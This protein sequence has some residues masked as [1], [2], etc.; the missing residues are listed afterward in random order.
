M[1]LGEERSRQE[2][3]RALELLQ[4]TPKND[5]LSKIY[6]E[7]DSA[8][9]PAL[10]GGAELQD[11]SELGKE[12][13]GQCRKYINHCLKRNRQ[14]EL[15]RFVRFTAA[16]GGSTAYYILVNYGWNL[17]TYQEYL[18]PAQAAAIRAEGIVWNIYGL[19][20][21]LSNLE[22]K[23]PQVLWEAMK[24]CSSKNDNAKVLLAAMSLYYSK[25]SEKSGNII[26][27]LLPGHSEEK[28]MQL[29]IQETVDFLEDNL[30]DSIQNLFDGAAPPEEDLEQMKRFV[31]TASEKE[32]V[33]KELFAVIQKTR[34]SEYLLSMLSAA[35]F[36][37]LDHSAMC[38]PFLHLAMAMDYCQNRTAVL[39]IC[40]QIGGSAWFFAHIK[41]F[42]EQMPIPKEDYM[43]W[44]LKNCKFGSPVKRIIREHPQVV[45]NLITKL[46]SEEYQS[47]LAVTKG[48]NPTLYQEL[49]SLGQEEF[50]AKL[51]EELTSHYTNGRKEA[52]QYLQGEAELSV[53]YPFVKDWRNNYDYN[54]RNCSKIYSLK[55]NGLDQ[56]LYRRAVVLE[57]LCMRAR[58]FVSY[59][60]G[61]YQ[62]IDRATI[63]EIFQVFEAEHVPVSYQLEAL[64][65]IYDSFYAEKEKNSFINDCMMVM[66]LKN[67][68]WGPELIRLSKD[69]SAI[70]RFL[71]IRV[72]DEY[73]AE[74]KEELLSCAADSAKQVREI[75]TAV[76]ESRKEWEPEILQMLASK[77]SKER[78]MAVQVLGR[79]G[80]KQYSE[81]LK[82]A[83]EKEKSKKIKE[84]LADCLGFETKAAE[85]KNEKTQKDLVKEILKGGK[86]RK[87]S[88]IYQEDKPLPEVHRKDGTLAS[89]EDLAAIMVCYADMSIPGFSKDAVQISQELNPEELA[90]YM[91]QIFVRF[92]EANA[93]AKKK[94]VLYAASVHGG[95]RIIPLL[96]AQI[97]EWPKVSRGA[98]A[99]EAV[100]ALAL[101]GSSTAL[102]LVDQISRKFKFRQVKAAAS[103]ALTYAASQLGITKEELED[104]IVPDLGFDERMEQTVDY[105]T[106][107]FRVVLTSTLELEVYDENGKRLK[108]LPAPGKRD[109]PDKAGAANAAFKLLKK[110]LKT[111]VS[112]QKLRMEQALGFARLW[113]VEQW[114]TLFVKNPVMHQFA[115]GLIWG[116]Y[117]DGILKDTFRYMEDGSFNTVEEEEYPL[118]ES[119]MIGLVHPIEMEEEQL[120]AWKE[121]LSDYEVIQPVEQLDR[122]VYRLTEEEKDQTELI[123]FGGKLL[124]GLSLSGKLQS[125]GW[126]RGSV[127]DAGG[128]YTFYREDQKIGVE[129][130]F[131][132]SFVGGENEEVTVYGAQFYQAGTVQRGSY[133]YDTI[134]KEHL[135]RLSEVSPRY[136]SEIVLQLTKAT[137][138]SQEQ[139]SYPECKE[140]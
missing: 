80:A 126:Y 46:T 71:C 90:F 25:P 29:R 84:L 121:Q 54:T 135:Y 79:W 119:A 70:V 116:C 1:N 60:H 110:Q 34:I 16:V 88:W 91:E 61:T 97:Q 95:E 40:L 99:S 31:R 98:M 36:L 22:Q 19:K 133:V 109:E 17:H 117:E 123:R 96:H 101:N 7:L 138:S 48:V 35:A 67:K 18:S 64:S 93:E 20:G 127:Q 105:G 118:P 78:E 86:K 30:V 131:S 139:L 13:T 72:M 120:S 113:K 104:R 32:S 107:S 2:L 28:E 122:P 137:A 15:G 89:E 27:K 81:V 130:E 68:E 73:G 55:K 132:G 87:I 69:G 50:C 8:E 24:L 6:L 38:R 41:D 75:L 134:K 100:K 111:V 12:A 43:V 112:N 14:E 4:L 47:L 83:Y 114:E 57:G 53:L 63:G 51:S 92:L 49:S 52:R 58:Y 56:Q 136:F 10:L 42:E 5:A 59:W 33:S 26:R 115:I 62:K 11:F 103:D 76:Y 74:Y 77:K 39:S 66:R 129:L 3:V 128:Y 108:N 102:L 9:D 140:R 85:D 65:G 21:A 124:N 45:R 94:W 125:L 37:A 106:R 82:E 23:S 44:C